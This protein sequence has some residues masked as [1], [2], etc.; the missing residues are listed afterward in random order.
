MFKNMQNAGITE[1]T[2]RIDNETLNRWD[3]NVNS[4]E[5][6]GKD[7]KNSYIVALADKAVD[8][9]KTFGLYIK[10]LE[11]WNEPGHSDTYLQ[12]SVMAQ[13]LTEVYTRVKAISPNME[14]VFGGDM[15]SDTSGYLKKVL[16]A[17]KT[18]VHWTKPMFDTLGVHMY[19]AQNKK[20]T[21]Y[22]LYTFLAN[23]RKEIPYG[24]PM[25]LG[26]VGWPSGAG[27]YEVD[28][29]TQAENVRI[30]YQFIDK[31]PGLLI[32][33]CT[34]FCWKDF[35]A[36]GAMQKY[37]LVDTAGRYKA[38]YF[39]YRKYAGKLADIVAPTGT[40]NPTQSGTPWATK[41]P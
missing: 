3:W 37:G 9:V 23:K 15:V 14:I 20:I 12:P 26:E 13:L 33:E 27:L 41:S 16:E 8:F 21:D 5:V 32:K 36:K 7:G 31:Y 29:P 17:G 40:A 19:I 6:D 18:Y 2:G 38:S 1:I 39:A 22:E 25:R 30:L 35:Y 24:M 28:E 34:W 11:V 4:A 10:R